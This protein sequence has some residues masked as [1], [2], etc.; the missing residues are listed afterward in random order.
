M[1]DVQAVQ[2]LLYREARLLDNHAYEEWFDLW[3]S[4]GE[5][6]YWV[7][8]GNDMVDPTREPS[9]MYDDRDRLAQRVERL[10]NRWAL[11]QDPAG[12]LVRS[13]GNVEVQQ[14]SEQVEV[15]STFRVLEYRRGV[16]YDWTGRLEHRLIESPAGLRIVSKKC[17][18]INNGGD[19]PLLSFLL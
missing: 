7:P 3:S 14:A 10:H 16:T 8:S 9:I 18:L 4:E 13:I 15:H 11:A 1:S 2:D 19:L 12:R 6:L 5:I 17:L